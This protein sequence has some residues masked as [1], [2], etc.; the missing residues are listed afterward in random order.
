MSLHPTY[1]RFFG[2]WATGWVCLEVLFPRVRLW[3][4]IVHFGLGLAVELV[5]AGIRKKKG[6]TGSETFWAFLGGGWA[7]GL[8]GVG[9]AAGLALRVFSFPFLVEGA[10]PWAWLAWGPWACLSAGLFG[11]LAV[12]FPTLGRHG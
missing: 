2:V 11:W 4:W 3:M 1:A 7:R 12:H 10:L 9:V 6:D 8:L 5:G